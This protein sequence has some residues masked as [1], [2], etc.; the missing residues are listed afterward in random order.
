VEHPKLVGASRVIEL[1]K[2]HWDFFL[3]DFV[4]LQLL[5]SM[6]YLRHLDPSWSLLLDLPSWL[7]GRLQWQEGVMVLQVNGLVVRLAKDVNGITSLYNQR[8]FGMDAWQSTE[9]ILT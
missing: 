3:E 2:W 1:S 8:V 9:L 6:S 5:A 4:D 7:K